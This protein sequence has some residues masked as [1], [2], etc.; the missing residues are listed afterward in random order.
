MSDKYTIRQLRSA[1]VTTVISISLVLFVLGL[2]GFFLLAGKRLSD[3]VREDEPVWVYLKDDAREADVLAFKKTLDA[4]K[5]VK[6]AQLI[7]KEM[8]L[9]IYREQ[10][11]EEDLIG[12]LGFNPLPASI[13]LKL[14]ADYVN[15]DSLAKIKESLLAH[16][17]AVAEVDYR[18]KQVEKLNNFTR[19]YTPYL[20]ILSVLLMII[21]I[22]LINNTIRLS[23][24]SKRF[25][26]KTMQLVGA[27][28]GF[29]RKPFVLTGIRQGVYGA[30]IATIMLGGLIYLLMK[31]LPEAK[32]LLLDEKLLGILVGFVILLGIL[33]G[34]IC[35]AL[36]VR[37]YLRVRSDA[38]YY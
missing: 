7:T 5:Y 6:S 34:W 32:P 29:I 25:M 13:E 14:Y 16:K 31:E 37:K 12:S 26:I 11:S 21:A 2:A 9:K 3:H 23:I 27:T 8:A 28:G 24:Y 19:K 22:A 1:S 18:S 17:E 38:L 33:I 36:A 20:L 10:V 4:E 15:M 30:I 35:T